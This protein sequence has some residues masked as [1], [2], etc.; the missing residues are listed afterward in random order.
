MQQVLAVICALVLDRDVTFQPI[1]HHNLVEGLHACVS[2]SA[3]PLCSASIAGMGMYARYFIA[4]QA[5]YQNQD[6]DDEEP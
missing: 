3:G 6:D 4:V 1:T 5:L 2:L